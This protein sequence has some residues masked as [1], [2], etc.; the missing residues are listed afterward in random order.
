MIIRHLDFYTD[1]AYSSKS[2]MGGWACVCIE[3]DVIIETATGYE[4]YSTN[5]RM[6][7]AALLCALEYVNQIE[8]RN[9][10]VNIYTDSAYLSNC[11]NE[12]WY[13][14]WLNNG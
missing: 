8:S 3:D 2:E 13:L 7:L 14:N 4:P 9:V 6:E 11:L 10:E 5:N 1:G 12:K